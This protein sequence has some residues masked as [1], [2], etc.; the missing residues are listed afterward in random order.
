[1]KE[2]IK[3]KYKIVTFFKAPKELISLVLNKQL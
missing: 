3:T 2:N 1:M